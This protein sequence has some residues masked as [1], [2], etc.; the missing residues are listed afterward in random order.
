M[1]PDDLIRTAYESERTVSVDQRATVRK[2]F[3]P[4]NLLKGKLKE[5]KIMRI[6]REISDLQKEID[7]KID[8]NGGLGLMITA[9]TEPHIT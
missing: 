3:E 8:V 6:S 4:L 2:T 1:V 9:G 5:K 7:Y